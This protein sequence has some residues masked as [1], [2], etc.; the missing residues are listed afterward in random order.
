[1]NIPYPATTLQFAHWAA[2]ALIN[3]GV[4]ERFRTLLIITIFQAL[5]QAEVRLSEREPITPERLIQVLPAEV[6]LE[7][8]EQLTARVY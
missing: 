3:Q 8:A 5:T 6:I 4:P 1:M 7:A 2:G